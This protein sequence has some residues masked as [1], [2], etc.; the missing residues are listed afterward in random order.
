LRWKILPKG[1]VRYH[2]G[3]LNGFLVL[4]DRRKGSFAAA[5]RDAKPGPKAKR[6]T[7][8]PAELEEAAE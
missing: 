5:T 4:G 7:A 2:A 6:R 3:A 8:A 1:F